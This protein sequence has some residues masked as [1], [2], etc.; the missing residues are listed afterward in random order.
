MMRSIWF[1]RALCPGGERSSIIVGRLLGSVDFSR[2]VAQGWSATIGATAQRITLMDDNNR[3]VR[4]DYQGFP[5][6]RSGQV[7]DHMFT[8]FARAAFSGLDSTQLVLSAE[9]AL[10]F[11]PDWLHITKLGARAEKST[12]LGPV[13]LVIY[14]KGGM[15]LGRL[16]PY[17]ASPL[18]GTNSIRGYPEGGVG[19]ARHYVEGTAELH[20]PLIG[21][22]QGTLF[23]DY[24]TDIGSKGTIIGNPG[25]N[26][27]KPGKGHGRGLG[28]RIDS[29]VGPLRLE[30]AWN[31]LGATRFHVGLGVHG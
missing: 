26:T 15:T 16:P 18:G 2:P 13:N 23:A 30:W 21:N 25:N 22:L 3:A 11:Q 1:L 10:P 12:R 27:Q 4:Q 14:T 6:N 31:D 5:V 20:I 17:E 9:Q 19:T 29:P 8:G 7:H 28:I 24:G